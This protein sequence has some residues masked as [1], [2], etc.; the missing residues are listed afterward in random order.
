MPISLILCL[1]IAVADGDTLTAH[2]DPSGASAPLKIRIAAID[3]PERKQA[4][5]LQ[6]RQ[7]LVQ[8][9]LQKKATLEALDVDR[10]GRTVANVRC[11]A[12]DVATAQVNAG[13]A[14]VYTHYADHHPHLLPLE[15]QARANKVGL[16]AEARPLAP[17]KYRQRYQAL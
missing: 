16:W 7:N 6:A 9:C 14:W 5:G 13:L 17:W 10:Y 4:H 3:A 12:T 1:V 11:G 15:Q 2:C 8:L